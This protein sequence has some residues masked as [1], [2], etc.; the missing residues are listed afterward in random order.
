MGDS[1]EKEYPTEWISAVYTTPDAFPL[2]VVEEARRLKHIVNCGAADVIHLRKPQASLQYTTELLDALYGDVRS[3]VMIHDHFELLQRYNLRG[4]HLNSRN[5]IAPIQAKHISNSF[6]T[7]E[8]FT[9]GT[10]SDYYTLSP[11]FDSISK[12]GYK[13]AFSLSELKGKLPEGKVVALGGVIPRE[14]FRLHRIGF[15]GSAILGWMWQGDFEERAAYLSLRLRLLRSFPLLLIT[16]AP[17]TGATIAQACAAYAGGCRWVQV[18]MKYADTTARATAARAIMERC[19]HMLVC[20]DDDCE[21]VRLSGAHGVHLGKND[22][23]TAEARKILGNVAIV[24]RT[25]N[26]FDDI[27]RIAAE[28]GG[29]VD[30]LGVGPLRFTTTKKR[31]APTLGFDGYHDITARMQRDEIHLPILAIGGITSDD[32][33]ELTAAGVDGVAV[34]GAINGSNDPTAAVRRFLPDKSL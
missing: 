4:V 1:S 13:S 16:D 2:G 14:L 30:Y 18:R 22:I 10:T 28:D 34:S 7:L 9:L 12:S 11:I 6:H 33:K 21:A 19:R 25:A 5:P 32:L 31:L 26:S 20:I 15:A 23:S 3:R 24:G 17:T 8:E 29:S 27:Q